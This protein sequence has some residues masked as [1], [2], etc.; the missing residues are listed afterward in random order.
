[1][2]KLI[3]LILILCM[4]CM[5]IPAMAEEA[6]GEWYLTS[7]SYG[8]QTLDA[9]AFGMSGTLTLKEDGTYTAVMT[10]SD[11]STGTWKAEGD[12]VQ[13]IVNDQTTE[14][15]IADGFLTIT[16]AESGSSMIFSK[17]APAAAYTPGEVNTEAKLEDFAGLWKASYVGAEGMVLDLSAY[18]QVLAAMM[19]EGTELPDLSSMMTFQIDGAKVTAA[20]GTEDAKTVEGTFADGKL[21]VK[22]EASG[23]DMTIFL[24]QDGVLAMETEMNGTASTLYCMSA[25]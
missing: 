12:K 1:M 7:M 18:I 19:P 15:T 24:L 20:A 11:E 3:S 22:D 17:E 25:N 5:L 13:I 8:G 9:A 16:D 21:T 2:K 23:T 14:A 6:A 10:G 4:A